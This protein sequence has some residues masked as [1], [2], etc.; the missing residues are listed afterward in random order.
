MRI[1]MWRD[2]KTR[3]FGNN[4]GVLVIVYS[5]DDGC[6]TVAYVKGGRVFKQ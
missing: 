6:V 4:L 1:S 5:I 3:E 2:R